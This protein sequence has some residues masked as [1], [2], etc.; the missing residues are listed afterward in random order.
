MSKPTEAVPPAGSMVRSGTE[1]ISSRGGR[2]CAVRDAV[3]GF[4]GHSHALP[5]ATSPVPQQDALR[6]FQ[7]L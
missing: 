7:L 3:P 2:R 4:D 5:A 1:V 6:A